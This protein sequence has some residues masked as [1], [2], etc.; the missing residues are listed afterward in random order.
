MMPQIVWSG[1]ENY[2]SRPVC[3]SA[4]STCKYHGVGIYICV[5]HT[6]A[7]RGSTRSL[8]RRRREF[9][10]LT[11]YIFYAT[12]SRRN[13]DCGMVADLNRTASNLRHMYMYQ[14]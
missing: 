11:A 7:L 2:I 6:D 1:D 10:D 4:T 5:L 13:K 12:F 9:P 3:E 8:V 14:A